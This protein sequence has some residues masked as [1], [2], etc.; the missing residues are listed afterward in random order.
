MIP[1]K[2]EKGDYV[3]FQIKNVNVF[4]VQAYTTAKGT[5]ISYEVPQSIVDFLKSDTKTKTDSITY[6]K[7]KVVSKKKGIPDV[8][9]L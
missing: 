6:R 3:K 9:D 4:K 7:K 1:K 5:D 2:F 8:A